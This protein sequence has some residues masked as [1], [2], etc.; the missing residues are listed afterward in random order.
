M[1]DE[2]VTVGL[3]AAAVLLLLYAI[4][5]HTVGFSIFNLL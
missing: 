5:S 4:V 1:M 2:I 3:I